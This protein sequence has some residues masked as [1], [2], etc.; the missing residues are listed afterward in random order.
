[1]ELFQG[2]HSNVSLQD[3]TDKYQTSAEVPQSDDKH[4]NLAR[5]RIDFN[6]HKLTQG[7]FDKLFWYKTLRS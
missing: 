2:L 6:P 3:L 4:S 7:Q 1:M 5:H